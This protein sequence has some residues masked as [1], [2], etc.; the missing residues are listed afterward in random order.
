MVTR[1]EEDLQPVD[2]LFRKCE[3]A[4]HDMQ[5]GVSTIGQFELW[6]VNLLRGLEPSALELREACENEEWGPGRETALEALESF[7]EG[8]EECQHYLESEDGEHLDLAL[9]LM[10]RANG[11]LEK[12]YEATL[13][14]AEKPIV[15]WVM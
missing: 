14:T 6:L 13:D 10:R 1:K 8:F 5:N 7:E 4:I 15:S 12:A 3:K 9:A 11:L 2:Q